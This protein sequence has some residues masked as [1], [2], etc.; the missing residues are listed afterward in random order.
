MTMIICTEIKTLKK[1]V[2]SAEAIIY[3]KAVGSQSLLGLDYKEAILAP[4]FLLL[5]VLRQRLSM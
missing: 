1:E 4:F 3:A 2:Y 5:F